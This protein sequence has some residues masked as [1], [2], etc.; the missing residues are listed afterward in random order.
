M[1]FVPLLFISLVS[2]V[3]CGHCRQILQELPDAKNIR[4]I[5][6]KAGVDHLL[7][8]LLP[9]SYASISTSLY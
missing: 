1:F 8:D 4:V 6:Q 7:S 9:Y 5:V 2:E 3:P